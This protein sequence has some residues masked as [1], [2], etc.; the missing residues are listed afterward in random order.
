MRCRFTK[1]VLLA[2]GIALL[3]GACS[4]DL[5]GPTYTM[6]DV[7][8]EFSAARLIITEEHERALRFDGAVERLGFVV[9]C[10]AAVECEPIEIEV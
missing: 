2:L 10:E 8:R 7:T 1:G 3:V 5:S 6:A 4:D 9:Q